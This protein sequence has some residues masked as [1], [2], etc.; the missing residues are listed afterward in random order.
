MSYPMREAELRDQLLKENEEYRRLAAE[1]QSCDDELDDLTNR[2]FL[3]EEDEL[4][5]KTLKKK[6]LML[7]DQM[8]SI[9]QRAR[10]QMDTGSQ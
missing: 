3:S 10:K 2:H 1:H 4:K 6:K 7:K 8:Y 5:E 9:V